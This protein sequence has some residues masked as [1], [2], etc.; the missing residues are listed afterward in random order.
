MHPLIPYF[1]QPTIPIGPLTIHGFGIM[2]ALG[3][4]LGG[5]LAERK[6]VA[7]SGDPAAAERMNRMVGWLVVG[8]IVGGHLGEILMYEPRVLLTDPM[9]LLRFWDGLSSFGGFMACVPLAVWFFRKEGVPF[10]PNGDALAWGFG[11]GFGLGRVGCFLAHDHPGTPT[12][13]WLGVKGICP[14]GGPELACHDM[15]LYEALAVFAMLG[16]FKLA[17]LRPRPPGFY[18]GLLPALYG[19]IRFAMEFMRADTAM[20]VRYAGLTP[21][22][23]GSLVLTG[24]GVWILATRGPAA[25]TAGTPTA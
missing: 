14:G 7:Y 12:N 16:V 21:A 17:S 2:V 22:Q 6:A 1:S 11:L 5:N 23:Y 4:W 24:L 25:A 13:F 9:K 8:T 3:F 19:P 15:G 18:I 20:D 10:W